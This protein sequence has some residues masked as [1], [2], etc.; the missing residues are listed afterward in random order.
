MANCSHSSRISEVCEPVA[1]QARVVYTSLH[2]G[3]AHGGEGVSRLAITGADMVECC[4]Q[5]IVLSYERK[6]SCYI[7]SS[8]TS[9]TI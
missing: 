8:L 1:T 9:I 2:A 6:Q 5:S 4:S 3:N 7:I